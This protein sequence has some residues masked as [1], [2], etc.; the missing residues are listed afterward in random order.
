MCETNAFY[1]HTHI[2][3]TGGSGA[4]VCVFVWFF[5][6]YSCINTGRTKNMFNSWTSNQGTNSLLQ[7][8]E[9]QFAKSVVYNLRE[10]VL[11]FGWH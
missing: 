9:I 5:E 6:F 2:N 3:R 7:S 11:Q 10:F 8:I 4:C 1:A